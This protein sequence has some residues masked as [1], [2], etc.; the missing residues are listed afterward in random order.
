MEDTKT[1]YEALGG[2]IMS[3]LRKSYFYLEFSKQPLS[4]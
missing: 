1:I 4:L 2:T 3:A